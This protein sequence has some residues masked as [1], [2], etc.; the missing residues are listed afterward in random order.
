MG[1]YLAK[2]DIM[3]E[4]EKIIFEEI[5]GLDKKKFDVNKK[6]DKLGVDSLDL[7]TVISKIESKYKIKITDNEL[8]KL[9]SPKLLYSFLKKKNVI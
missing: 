4:I 7:F 9:T 3:K 1:N 8:K 5:D 6:F 2:K